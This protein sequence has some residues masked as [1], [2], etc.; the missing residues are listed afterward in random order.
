MSTGRVGAPL[1]VNDFMLVSWEEASYRITDK[2]Y[3]RGEIII[4][5]FKNIFISYLKV[6]NN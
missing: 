3:P 4:G 2:P 5:K 6:F 1:T